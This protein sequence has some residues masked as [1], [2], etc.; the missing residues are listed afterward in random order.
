MKSRDMHVAM[1]EN[2]IAYMKGAKIQFSCKTPG[3][4]GWDD[5][6]ATYNKKAH[7]LAVE[8]TLCHTRNV[9]KLL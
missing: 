6:I 7:T 8:C 4:K 9:A 1:R 5:C 2:S 3:C